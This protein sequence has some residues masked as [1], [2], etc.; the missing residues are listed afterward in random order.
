MFLSSSG[1]SPL[2]LLAEKE[3]D[4]DQERIE[5]QNEARFQSA[6]T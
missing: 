4:E 1:I 5:N 6:R 2:F 3:I